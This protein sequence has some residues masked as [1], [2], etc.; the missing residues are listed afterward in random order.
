[1][2]APAAMLKLDPMQGQNRPLPRPEIV[3]GKVFSMGVAAQNLAERTAKYYAATGAIRNS[4]LTTGSNFI[5]DYKKLIKLENEDDKKRLATMLE[6][7]LET[8]KPAN[9]ADAKVAAQLKVATKQWG[10][11]Q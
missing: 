11:R 4:Y 5:A 9:D 8:C 6:R 7:V 3:I 10:E 2:K 1:M